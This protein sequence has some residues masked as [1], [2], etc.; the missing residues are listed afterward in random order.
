MGCGTSTK[1]ASWN[2]SALAVAFA[3]PINPEVTTV[4]VGMPSLSTLS[5]ST[6]SHEV[7]AP[8]SPCAPN[9]RSGFSPANSPAIFLL[10]SG[11]WLICMENGAASQPLIIF[12]PGHLSARRS[13]IRFRKISPLC[14]PF[15]WRKT[16]FPVRSDGRTFCGDVF[17]SLSSTP[18]GFRMVH[19]IVSM[20]SSPF[21][22][23]GYLFK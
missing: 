19:G 2:P 20:R 16:V 17:G 3:R 22:I 6:T 10:V 9:T 15:Q 12:T 18:S 8:Q 14:F 11:L 1:E 21:L 5:W 4:T 7:Q 13:A 23:F